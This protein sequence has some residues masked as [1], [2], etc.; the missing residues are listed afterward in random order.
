MRWAWQCAS[1]AEDTSTRADR[2]K[3]AIPVKSFMDAMSAVNVYWAQEPIYYNSGGRSTVGTVAAG[4]YL[5]VSVCTFESMLFT[6]INF[7]ITYSMI[8]QFSVSDVRVKREY[9]DHV[10]ED[11]GI[12]SLVNT[13][14]Y[15]LI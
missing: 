3:S 13:M 15:V 1:S 5:R 9:N 4:T 7:E 11:V 10:I 12:I 2:D 14:Y 8:A 6:D